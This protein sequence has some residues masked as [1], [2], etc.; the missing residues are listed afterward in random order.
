MNSEFTEQQRQGLESMEQ[1]LPKL[2]SM[3]Q[4]MSALRELFTKQLARNQRH[5]QMFDA[6][7]KE[8]KA[9]KDDRF[10][11]I[12]HKPV[13][14]NLIRLYDNFKEVESQLRDLKEVSGA[15]G[16]E[17]NIGDLI[18]SVFNDRPEK[19]QK[20]LLKQVK[21]ARSVKSL[22]ERLQSIQENSKEVQPKSQ[23]GLSQFQKNLENVRV[24]LEEVLCRMEVTPYTEHPERLNM[25][26]HQTVDTI[27]TDDPDKDEVVVEIR[28]S[29]F[30]WREQIFRLEEVIIY[31]YKSAT[32]ESSKT[33]DEK[34]TKGE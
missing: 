6:V 27:E 25:E 30:K 32:G 3:E 28:K 7:Y 19:E 5:Q 14:N 24:Q 1:L 15:D 22:A 12:F 2:V 10:R 23:V 18:V 4:E 21:S 33:V 11:E 9:Y 34:S 16:S 17:V 8:M 31:R 29:G 13:I 26:M 20:K